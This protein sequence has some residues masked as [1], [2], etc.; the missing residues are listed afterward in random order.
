M[1]GVGKAGAA[2]DYNYAL[3]NLQRHDVV[4]RFSDID[5]T[6]QAMVR[7]VLKAEEEAEQYPWAKLPAMVGDP[8]NLAPI[9]DIEG[10]KYTTTDRTLS[11][12]DE[13]EQVS[14]GTE[15]VAV[16]E[17]GAQT[18]VGTDEA[19]MVADWSMGAQKFGPVFGGGIYG[20][21]YP[22]GM[23][24]A[25]HN[26]EGRVRPTRWITMAHPNAVSDVS[27]GYDN[28][29]PMGEDLHPLQALNA[30]GIP[31]WV[32]QLRD[33]YLPNEHDGN[34]IAQDDAAKEAAW[35]SHHL[36]H[37]D[38]NNRT[39]P[40]LNHNHLGKI[41]VGSEH[42]HNLYE[43]NYDHWLRNND[44]LNRTGL[45]EHELRKKHMVE[46]MKGWM[47]P[48]TTKLPDGSEVNPIT[49]D[50][51]VNG[52]SDL[53]YHLG[54][55]WLL[56]EEK[57][58]VYQHLS[59]YSVGDR[60]KNR[61]KAAGNLSIG[62][63]KRNFNQRFSPEYEWFGRDTDVLGPNFENKHIPVPEKAN[64]NP[65]ILRKVLTDDEF[66]S[67]M[68]HY[69][70]KS[71]YL[72]VKNHPEF[73]E[74]F[75]QFRE[76]GYGID[77][78]NEQTKARVISNMALPNLKG[79][80][81]VSSDKHRDRDKFLTEK[82]L[83]SLAGIVPPEGDEKRTWDDGD[84]DSV[85]LKHYTKGEH[86]H[87]LNGWDP[88]N[89]PLKISQVKNILDRAEGTAGDYY[90]GRRLR[91]AMQAHNSQYLDPDDHP[92][93][94]GDNKSLS[95][96][97]GNPYRHTG[98]FGRPHNFLIDMKHENI[99]H[100]D[101]AVDKHGK[102]L[103]N[104]ISIFGT[105][106]KPFS[107][108]IDLSAS[109][110]DKED[111][112]RRSL[113]MQGT[114][115]PRAGL[116]IHPESESLLASY[117]PYAD[118]P[119]KHEVSDFKRWKTGHME[120]GE[121]SNIH[122]HPHGTKMEPASEAGAKG[123][124]RLHASH[125]NGVAAN[126]L[127]REFFEN[128]TNKGNTDAGR[129][130]KE[131]RFGGKSTDFGIR[132]PFTKQYGGLFSSSGEE[133]E[134]R[135]HK[136]ATQA[137]WASHPM[138][139]P[140]LSLIRHNALGAE[141]QENA[142]T[143]I[144]RLKGMMGT[145]THEI[146]GKFAEDPS[147]PRLP[148]NKVESWREGE[149]KREGQL[150]HEPYGSSGTREDLESK[151]DLVNDRI[152]ETQHRL[153]KLDR[154]SPESLELRNAL[155]MMNGHF[156]SLESQIEDMPG[157]RDK[158]P[159]D[160]RKYPHD[161][162]DEIYGHDMAAIEGEVSKL[163]KQAEDDG[164]QVIIPGDPDTSMGN[165]QNL[166]RI[167]NTRL[168]TH[169]H[170]NHGAFSLGVQGTPQEK[171]VATGGE[172]QESI[173]SHVHNNGIE[174]S[175]FDDDAMFHGALGL[176]DEDPLHRET[177]KNLKAQLRNKGVAAGNE[178]KQFKVMR[179]EDLL[180]QLPML[181]NDFSNEDSLIDNIQRSK[182]TS[183]S[184]GGGRGIAKVR[185]T[186]P[187]FHAVNQLK[188][189]FDN[190]PELK[191]K[192][193]LDWVRAHHRHPHVMEKESRDPFKHVSART[194][195]EKRTHGLKGELREYNAIQNMESALI[196]D[197]D[198]EPSQIGKVTE[199]KHGIGKVPIGEGGTPHGNA[200]SSIFDSA[201][202]R[203]DYGWKRHPTLHADLGKNGEVNFHHKPN[204]KATQLLTLSRESIQKTAP[205]LMDH[206]GQHHAS[207][208]DHIPPQFRP[209]EM[210]ESPKMKGTHTVRK[211]DGPTLLASLTNPDILLKVDGDKPPPLQPMHRI[212]E[213]EDLEELKG[214]TG[215]WVVTLMPEGERI[216]IKRDDD[217]V[218]AW[219]A[220]SGKD[221]ELSDEEKESLKKTTEKNFMI[222]VIKDEEGYQV[223]DIL[224]FDDKD[225]HD[226][227]SQDRIK[228]LRGGMES[229]ENILLPAAYNTR[230]T[231]DAGLESVITDLQKEGER[232]LLRDAKST[233]MV[234]EK[235]QPKWVLL[236]PGKDVNL[237]I[238]EKRG[239]GPYTYRLGTGPITQ[240]DKI[241]DRA[242]EID[243]E[244]YMDVGSAFHSED[245]YDEGD[246]V[247]VNVNSVTSHEIE[248]ETV[249][250]IH[251]G[252]IKEEA[253]GEGL[254]SQDT[255]SILTKCELWPH[256]ISRRGNRI[257]ISFSQGAIVYKSTHSGGNWSV[258]S[259]QAKNHLL[260]RLA[261]SQR[262]FWAPVVGTMLKGNFDMVE[263]KKEEVSESKDEGEPIIPP[264]KVK[265]T[266]HW[267]KMVEALKMIEKTATSWSG[268]K[269]L[270]FDY[271][272]P[273]E[274]PHGPT[275][276][277]DGS[278]M[279]DYDNRK[280]PGEDMEK[281]YD[282]KG[283]K[284]EEIDIPV[285]TEDGIAL[286]HVDSDSAVIHGG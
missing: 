195:H 40:I 60:E 223:F 102:L 176:N 280:R 120:G 286:L 29:N 30:Q 6:L 277:R 182:E 276:L 245:E 118:T 50:W 66:N 64:Y 194:S 281:P 28:E 264:K 48:E 170:D 216:F 175:G 214:F 219:S 234:G 229:H 256:E 246:H 198:I 12:K 67:L 215:D 96:H 181:G 231:D 1:D 73:K 31:R 80:T 70:S 160:F 203:M 221:V 75:N 209:N 225:V 201:G 164:H 137:Q 148:S 4:K 179:V 32:T 271:G 243:D 24:M 124:Y 250:T 45:S 253:E 9:P 114:A 266:D 152:I 131:G 145:G 42:N 2:A 134:A 273:I 269:G 55:E 74:T 95:H 33:F 100:P 188:T 227:S 112:V 133:A 5:V 41:D 178:A 25:D 156:S 169:K 8:D 239:E 113:L 208:L 265:G 128:Y 177:V 54:L 92:H 62:R 233:Y 255:L 154:D 57:D 218:K 43:K 71:Q 238:L 126:A 262:P 263:E 90:T 240:D 260:I 222:D 39:H 127:D 193:G 59:R 150:Q 77:E 98:G 186:A 213:I 121:I 115:A 110:T 20:V 244:T 61:V 146:S 210:G 282:K 211:H 141:H 190:E 140:A 204:G 17:S 171:N 153:G 212:F 21:K 205:E 111:S 132:N 94:G 69:H 247:K 103:P 108:D 217:D 119:V 38:F 23:M 82:S 11:P 230:L 248:G 18:V 165:L 278:T 10:S 161:S 197:P 101:E 89:P 261:E 116:V 143:D 173:K 149:M 106:Q 235:R 117:L 56:P 228:V 36:N 125:R 236:Q 68:N 72:D 241:G 252:D 44:K 99:A 251:A 237:I 83:F 14:E 138:A 85:E 136:R 180:K 268:P 97:W 122:L 257:S 15:G 157:H 185:H 168:N 183:K 27:E 37:P 123:Q 166:Y 53:D 139:P 270:G 167:A 88:N 93:T 199:N 81:L 49:S 189:L 196:S 52:L 275:A 84:R 279:P 174:L 26:W 105:K 159:H 155:E 51:R 202:D 249:Y 187:S 147:T 22:E 274:S 46:A 129:S 104:T 242:V 135:R 3:L 76:H 151:L 258:H 226:E 284:P 206:L 65:E 162:H 272:T 144:K 109:S 224:E 19:N 191:E 130:L 254:A 259:P 79:N 86:S 87:G 58:A 207:P 232:I 35:E 184:S 283:K 158:E 267:D 16:S 220:T 107:K 192:L 7:P 163:R 63:L 285:E 91:N 172:L 200:I 13:P 78:A 34:S 47:S 142:S